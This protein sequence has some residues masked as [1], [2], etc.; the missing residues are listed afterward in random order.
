MSTWNYPSFSLQN[1]DFVFNRIGLRM[2]GVSHIVLLL[3]FLLLLV[4][5][6]VLERAGREKSLDLLVRNDEGGD[7]NHDIL[8]ENKQTEIEHDKEDGPNSNHPQE[9]QLVRF[10]TKYSF[11]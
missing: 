2:R 11:H 5:P 9:A 4:N 10:E 6:C 1:V 7:V 3:S 8:V